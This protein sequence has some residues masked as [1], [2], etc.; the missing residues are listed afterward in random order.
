MESKSFF[1]TEFEN[2]HTERKIFKPFTEY[3]MEQF[4]YSP[5]QRPQLPLYTC[6][7]WSNSLALVCLEYIKN[8]YG[9]KLGTIRPVRAWICRPG[10]VQADPG[11]GLD[12]H[13]GPG[14]GPGLG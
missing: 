11:P 6:F 2:S 10:Q 12:T 13:P 1:G 7:I 8:L 14:P 9:K 5:A 3:G 4:R